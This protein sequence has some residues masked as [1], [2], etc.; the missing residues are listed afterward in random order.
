MSLLETFDVVCLKGVKQAGFS[1]DPRRTFL[2]QAIAHTFVVPKEITLLP[3]ICNK[4]RNGLVNA[5]P[6]PEVV[7]T[8][9]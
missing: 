7:C 4:P 2:C 1:V 6:K 8:H 3:Y 5:L 9:L